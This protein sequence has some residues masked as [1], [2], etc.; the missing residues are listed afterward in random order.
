MQS[1]HI[2]IAHKSLILVGLSGIFDQWKRGIS[3]S[4]LQR[5]CSPLPGISYFLT[6]L[7]LRMLYQPKIWLFDIL[8]MIRNNQL[9]LH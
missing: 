4:Y 9:F 2:P 7:L 3:V 1:V 5:S 8:G 6:L